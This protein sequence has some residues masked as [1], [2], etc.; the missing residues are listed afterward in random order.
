MG[1][2]LG[3]F[4]LTLGLVLGGYWLFIVRPEDTDARALRKRLKAPSLRPMLRPMVRDRAR[5]SAVGPV[6]AVLARSE[7]LF[8]PL[9]SLIVRSGASVNL[10][11]VVLATVFLF[12]I[13]FLLGNFLASTF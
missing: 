5:L 3:V 4:L 12:L 1:T 6:E 11:T 2:V 13:G 7:G 9:Q 10:G 8:Q